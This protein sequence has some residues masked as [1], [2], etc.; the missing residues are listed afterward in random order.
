MD[1]AR[2]CRTSRDVVVTVKTHHL[3]VERETFCLRSGR[4]PCAMGWVEP[5]ELRDG[6]VC[7]VW[8]VGEGRAC[9]EVSAAAVVHAVPCARAV[10]AVFAGAPFV[11]DAEA[12]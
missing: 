7:D 3:P 6:A 2:E 11:L 4:P 9:C 1:A 12:R 5:R 8:T 10:G